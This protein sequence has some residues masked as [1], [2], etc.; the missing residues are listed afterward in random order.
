MNATL[1][2]V[3]PEKPTQNNFVESFNTKLRDECLNKLC[4]RAQDEARYEI[5]LWHEH[6]NDARPQISLNY[7][8]PV[9]HAK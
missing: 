3:L 9:K 6:H 7:M 5:E 1:S 2:F 8:S 4:F